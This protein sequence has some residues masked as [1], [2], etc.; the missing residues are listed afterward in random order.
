MLVLSL[1]Q[2]GES[3]NWSLLFSDAYRPSVFY[4]RAC[5]SPRDSPPYR[6]Q[7]SPPRTEPVQPANHEV[8][9]QCLDLV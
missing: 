8:F 3:S 5:V 4:G 9:P 7:E 6:V 1:C 2:V